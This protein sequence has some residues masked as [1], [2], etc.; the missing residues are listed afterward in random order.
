MTPSQATGL[1]EPSHYHHNLIKLIY[2]EF[3]ALNQVIGESLDMNALPVSFNYPKK[4]SLLEENLSD[5]L[6]NTVILKK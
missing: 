3:Q 2:D 4:D 1:N 6:K 5:L